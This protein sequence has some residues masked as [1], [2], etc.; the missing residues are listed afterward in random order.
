MEGY[1]FHGYMIIRIGFWLGVLLLSWGLFLDPDRALLWWKTLIHHI[2]FGLSTF[3]PMSFFEFF[4][5]LYPP[6]Y[7]SASLVFLHLGLESGYG[8][9]GACGSCPLLLQFLGCLFCP[10]D[11]LLQLCRL[12]AVKFIQAGEVDG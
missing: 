7:S 10:V 2:I 5:F 4:F 6:T 1:S 3:I 9:L 11:L 12:F 8:I